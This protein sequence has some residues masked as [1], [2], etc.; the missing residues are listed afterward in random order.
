MRH[1][2]KIIHIEKKVREKTRGS[3]LKKI[4]LKKKNLKKRK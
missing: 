4:K 1:K 2:I 3:I